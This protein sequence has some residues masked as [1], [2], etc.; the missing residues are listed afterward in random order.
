MTTDLPLLVVALGGNALLRRGEPL[1]AWAQLDNIRR[2]AAQLAELAGPWR[3]VVTH[4]NGP[5]VGLLA[6]QNEAYR[7]VHP[8]PLDVLG[9]QTEGMI[10]YLLEQ[11][12]ANRLPAGRGVATLLTRIAV[13][14]ADPAFQAPSKPI[15]PVFDAARGAAMAHERGWRMVADGHGLR[16]AVPS[17]RPQ[18]VLGLRSIRVL[19]DDGAVVI[20]A[21]GGGIPV[22]PTGRAGEMSGVEAVI[23][24]DLA[25][26]LLA[27]QLG[28]DLLLIATDVR[29]VALDWGLPTQRDIRAASP[30]ALATLPFAMGTI[31]PKV[32]AACEFARATGRPAVIG[33]LEDI[34]RLARRDSGTW[35][36]AQADGIRTA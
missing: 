34:G 1:E 10:G 14:A 19:L 21:G 27:R 25:A 17:P 33:S 22:V 2:A 31:G 9:A 32:A 16:R 29:A 13:D 11:E 28:A 26:S 3:L 5:Q 23:D 4:G 15:G 7:D 30:D 8:Y 6:L 18:Q 20:C 35:I 24:K 36:D 12:I